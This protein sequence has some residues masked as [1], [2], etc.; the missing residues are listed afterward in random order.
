MSE[1]ENSFGPILAVKKQSL[2]VTMDFSDMCLSSDRHRVEQVLSN[3]ISNAS[4]YSGVGS[5]IRLT[6]LATDGQLQFAVSD[7]GIGISPEDLDHIGTPFFRVDGE[8][9]RI[10]G[11]T[12][13]GL[14]VTRSI[15]ELHGGSFEITSEQG[16]GTTVVL[17]FPGT[18]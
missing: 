18:P 13:L 15:V 1:I 8:Q 7:R 5:T 4:K 12:G 14:Y 9:S 11:G 2:T 17:R 6:V 10:V 16:H 3:I